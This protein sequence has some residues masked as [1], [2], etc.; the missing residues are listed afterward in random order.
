[1]KRQ[2]IFT[3]VVAL[4]ALAGTASA[5]PIIGS[6]GTQ[7]G[8]ADVTFGAGTVSFTLSNDTLVTNSA[9]DLLTK[10]TLKI[11]GLTG[12][13]ATS[14]TAAGAR[15]VDGAGGFSDV[16]GPHNL[17]SGGLNTWTATITGD[18]IE[19]NFNPDAKYAL[20]GD[21]SG[22]N[23]AAGNGS[24]KSNPGHTP[25]AYE[26]VSFSFNATGVTAGSTVADAH[27]IFGTSFETDVPGGG[28]GET[29]EPASLGVLSLGAVA[30]LARRRK[31]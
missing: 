23:Y 18:T 16:A 13:T 26:T 4:T 31:A 20:I 1:M 22:G 12:G 28:G 24:I 29:P 6:N 17:L 14:G 10:F 21:P 27:F 25:F 11:N 3:A 7:A 30:L 2:A 15:T 19:V 5:F 9:G 8:S